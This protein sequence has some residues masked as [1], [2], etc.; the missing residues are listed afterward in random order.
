MTRDDARPGVGLEQRLDRLSVVGAHRDLG[1]VH[2]AVGASD[3]A[4]VLL[5]R[6]L[7]G[8]RELRDRAA[9]RGLGG[10]AAGVRVDLGVE[11]Q[12]VDVPAGAQ[13]L[14]QAAEADVVG[15]AVAADDPDALADEIAGEREEALRVDLVGAV[16][17]RELRR[18]AWPPARAERRSPARCPGRCRAAR[19]RAPRRP[20]A[21]VASRA[22]RACSFWA[23]T[24]RRMPRP[25][26]ALSSNS[27][28]FQA[29]PRPAALIVHGVVGRLAP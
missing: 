24:P 19:E 3:G 10:L 29:G 28:L 5:A 23:S 7:A 25:N 16:D 1:H 11:D 4:E 6:A 14:V 17:R 2:V 9:R 13:D 8:R 20:A 15:P 26:S 18:E 21:R 22:A 27:E 12:D